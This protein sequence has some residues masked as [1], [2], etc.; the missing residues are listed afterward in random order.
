MK[1]T[2]DTAAFVETLYRPFCKQQLYYHRPFIESPGLW[3]SLFPNKEVKNLVIG[4]SGVGQQKPFSAIITDT[5]S[6]L[7]VVDKG[8]YFPLYWYEE[9]KAMQVQN[10]FGEENTDRW[11]QRDG[12]TDWMLN[13]VRS[14]FL[15][16]KNLTKEDIFYYVYGLLHS[17]DYRTRF[18]DDLRKA[19]P[20]IPIVERVENFMAF[21]KAGRALAD[22]HLNYE[23]DRVDIQYYLY[24]KK[25]METSCT[26]QGEP[27]I[28]S[29]EHYEVN[30]MRF[31]QENLHEHA[32]QNIIY[33][34]YITIFNIPIEAYDYVVN[35]K[36]A[37]E[38]I[39][40]RYA[41]TI[42]KKSG[43][44]NDPNLW[45]REQGKPRY[46][47]DLLLSIIRVSLETQ[48]IVATLPKL[49]F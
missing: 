14:R 10:L 44:K 2:F 24:E 13:E 48:R 17:P 36:S 25:I 29:P 38:W 45:S 37:I 8:Q 49:T 39:M 31:M 9:N 47:L 30:K 4:V 7:Q 22:L 40:E 3:N 21:S 42:D 34:N 32:K 5:I 23:E 19:L 18:A 6:D 27:V 41:V 46:I 11:I 28:G 43:I 12:V 20:R 16:A 35:G 33:N 1:H 26:V 15:G